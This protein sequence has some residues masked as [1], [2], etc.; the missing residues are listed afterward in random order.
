MWRNSSRSIDYVSVSFLWTKKFNKDYLPVIEIWI[1]SFL[2]D[3][4][5]YPCFS[6]VSLSLLSLSVLLF[7]IFNF[8]FHV[9]FDWS[10]ST[11]VF[12][13]LAIRHNARTRSVRQSCL[14]MQNIFV[15]FVPGYS[16]II[17]R[18]RW[19]SWMR[20]RLETRRSRVRPPPRS[21]TFFRGDWS[22]N[23]FYG[24]SLPSADSRKAV[25]SF[26]WKNVHNTGQPLGGL[27]LPSK[28]V[29]R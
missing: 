16:A 17:C 1:I 13:T 6:F 3:K 9:F 19:R 14:Y 5:M 22:W 7:K 25:V 10:F 18:P 11:C 12:A 27:S 15:L 23:I 29:V 8:Q 21:A 26:W 28:R 4:F 20:V 2:T 24:H